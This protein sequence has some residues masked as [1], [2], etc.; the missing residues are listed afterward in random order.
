MLLER[1]INIGL[2]DLAFAWQDDAL[3]TRVGNFVSHGHAPN[4][5]E[6][7]VPGCPFPMKGAAR[8]SGSREVA[9]GKK[10]GNEICLA[11]W[12]GYESIPMEEE[13]LA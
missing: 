10:I 4:S 12:D 7:F 9:S 5:E 13:Q 6:D 1:A 11:R 8:R 2:R 3:Q